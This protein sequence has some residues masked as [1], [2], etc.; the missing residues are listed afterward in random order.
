MDYRLGTCSSCK[1]QFR[2]PATFKADRAKCKKCAGVVELGP[3]QSEGQSEGQA[4]G[5]GAKGSAA[6]RAAGAAATAAAPASK[7][8]PKVPAKPVQPKAARTEPAPQKRAKP[9]ARPASSGGPRQVPTGGAKQ[10]SAGQRKA[11]P[12][13]GGGPRAAQRGGDSVRDAAEAAAERVRNAGPKRR[14]AAADAGDAPVRQGSGRSASRSGRRAGGRRRPEKKKSKAPM[15]AGLAVLLAGGGAAAWFFMGQGG[16]SETQAAESAAEPVTDELAA[17]E[18]TP[19]EDTT[20]GTEDPAGETLAEA[21]A[22]TDDAAIE[23]EAEAEAAPEP[24]P[25]SVDLSGLE[26]YDRLPE[27]PAEQWE[28]LSQL[29]ATMIDPG[30]GAAGGRARNQLLAAGIH[31]MPALVN[32]LI[33]LDFS[34]DQGYRDGDLVQKTMMDIC[35]GNNYGWKYSVEAKDVVYNKKVAGLWYRSWGQVVDNREAWV[36]LGKLEGE[37]ADEFLAQFAGVDLDAP[38]DES[39]IG[40]SDT[41]EDF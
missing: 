20:Q 14:P 9:A 27:T 39:D 10:R 28:E 36:Q 15:L 33:A 3:V 5:P 41:L 34:T 25:N 12:R 23:A 30:A 17:A 21:A 16:A 18:T 8:K 37:E 6:G 22:A 31:A 7:P 35:K 24:D 26:P 11:A 32:E 40:S 4:D 13:A 2:V 19:V 29:A 38:V 1:A